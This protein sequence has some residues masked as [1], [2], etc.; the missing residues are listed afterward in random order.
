M[1]KD[2]KTEPS[3]YTLAMITVR[4]CYTLRL[5]RLMVWQLSCKQ[6]KSQFDSE[7]RLCRNKRIGKDRRQWKTSGG[8]TRRDCY[9]QLIQDKEEERT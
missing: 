4:F 6:Q 2:M 5:F 1:R 3:T 8:S 9:I 7:E